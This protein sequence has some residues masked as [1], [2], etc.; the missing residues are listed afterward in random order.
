MGLA[1]FGGV[2]GSLGHSGSLRS[3]LF[4]FGLGVYEGSRSGGKCLHEDGAGREA[5]I[6]ILD[7]CGWRKVAVASIA[8]LCQTNNPSPEPEALNPKP[9]P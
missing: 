7:T 3:R 8:V 9:E 1:C 6:A 4:G 2:L 5:S